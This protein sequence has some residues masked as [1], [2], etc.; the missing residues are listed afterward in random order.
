MERPVI[1][2]ARSVP[3]LQF[4]KPAQRTRRVLS[5]ELFDHDLCLLL[6]N[7]DSSTPAPST[8]DQPTYE[9]WRRKF[10]VITGLGGTKEER[11]TDMEALHHSRCEKWKQ[12][13][14]AYSQY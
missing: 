14:M 4:G 8:A 6:M 3:P 13:L 9:R 10:S 2:P 11:A 7:G 1:L 12:E 5:A